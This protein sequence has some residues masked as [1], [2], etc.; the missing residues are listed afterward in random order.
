MEPRRGIHPLVA[1]VAFLGL[2]TVLA[3][4]LTVRV[5]SDRG[6]G[7]RTE[8]VLQQLKLACAIYQRDY[9]SYPPENGFVAVLTS[10][11]PPPPGG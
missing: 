7:T 1:G 10:P 5:G 2:A 8:F 6:P 9:G 3:G 4:L 11:P